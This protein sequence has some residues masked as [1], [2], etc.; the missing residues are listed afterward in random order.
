MGSS[1][2]ARTRPLDSLGSFA[3]SRRTG[4]AVTLVTAVAWGLFAVGVTGQWNLTRFES[5]VVSLA[6]AVA[7]GAAVLSVVSYRPGD[8]LVSLLVTAPVATVALTLPAAV[9]LLLSVDYPGRFVTAFPDLIATVETALLEPLGLRDA[10]VTT[11]DREGVGYLLWCLL[12]ALPVGW[13]AGSAAAQIAFLRAGP[14][15][16]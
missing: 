7:T 9:A 4:I 15:R 11:F 12:A 14:T 10:F 6:W 1:D 2:G 3:D 13:I 8:R 5:N 16:D